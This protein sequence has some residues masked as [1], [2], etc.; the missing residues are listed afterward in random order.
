MKFIA[1]IRCVVVHF[2]HTRARVPI[3]RLGARRG[4]V[5]SFRSV[6]H[7]RLLS[8]P[9]LAFNPQ[10]NSGGK[11]ST[12]AIHECQR[13]G[14]EVRVLR[15]Q[16][17]ERVAERRRPPPLAPTTPPPHPEKHAKKSPQKNQ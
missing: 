14:H 17:R 8:S 4:T 2:D 16:E 6:T 12:F 7:P 9:A 10:T 1:L 3:A 13:Q 11:D 15:A 5:D